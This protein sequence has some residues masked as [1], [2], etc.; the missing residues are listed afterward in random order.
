EAVEFG[1]L[2]SEAPKVF[3]RVADG[4]SRVT[5]IVSAMRGYSHPVSELLSP[6]DLNEALESALIIA[7]HEYKYVAEIEKN[8]QEIPEIKADSSELGQVFINLIVN[9]AH[10]IE[11]VVEG[12]EERGKISV[13]TVQTEDQVS[14]SIADT[15]TGIPLDVQKR[16]FEPF[17]TTK[18]VGRG[19]G[20]GLSIAYDI[21]V[22]KYGGRIELHSEPGEGSRFDLYLPIAGDANVENKSE[23]G[24]EFEETP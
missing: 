7:A 23:R 19:T 2:Q 16:I 22:R 18:P 17:F 4:L 15:G 13:T 12:T 8:F 9:A 3:Q 5:K 14:V 10:A 20:Q 11:S 1:F 6:I 24:P 21:I